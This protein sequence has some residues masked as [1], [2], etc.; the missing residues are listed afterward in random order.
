M[1]TCGIIRFHE[2]DDE[3]IEEGIE[4]ESN[5]TTTG[6]Q[7]GLTENKNRRRKIVI[8]A[9]QSLQN[10]IVQALHSN[11]VGLLEGCL[12][13]RN[14]ELI[15]TT[16]RRLPTTY[17]IPLLLQLVD[18][19]QETPSR[20]QDIMDWVQP[21]LKLHIAYLMT[22]PDLVGKLSNFYQAID[23]RASTL[24]KLLS[25]NGHLDI[26]N[27]Q[28]NVKT[29]KLGSLTQQTGKEEKPL[30]TYVEQISDDEAEELNSMNEGDSMDSMDYDMDESEVED[31]EN[32]DESEVEFEVR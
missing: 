12:Q 23:A 17:V 1:V 7:N 2:N 5:G 14:P 18:K 24:P 30:Y 15:E 3:G 28:I 8:P 13:H 20:A 29:H 19:F 32:D 6:E 11:D 26:V 31:D 16:V 22:V 25:L 10:A 9:A 21:T 4:E 27:S